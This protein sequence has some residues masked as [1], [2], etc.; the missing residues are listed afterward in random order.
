MRNASR[1]LEQ[2]NTGIFF[3]VFL[4]LKVDFAFTLLLVSESMRVH[5]RYHLLPQRL[6]L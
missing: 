6:V 1:K 4:E 2:K 3:P 5:H